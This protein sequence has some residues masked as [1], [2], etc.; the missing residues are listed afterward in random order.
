MAYRNFINKPWC[1]IF[2]KQAY[3]LLFGYNIHLSIIDYTCQHQLG[4]N[5]FFQIWLDF[6]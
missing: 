5:N 2:N 6:I 3:R 4:H 1:F